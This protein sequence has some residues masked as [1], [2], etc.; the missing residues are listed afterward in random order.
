MKD[1][2]WI[3]L[4]L[5]VAAIWGF[6]FTATK[7]ALRSFGTFALLFIRFFIASCLL[8]GYIAATRKKFELHNA[9]GGIVLGV[10]A[11]F[12]YATQTFGLNFTSAANSAFITYLLVIFVPILSI[13]ILKKKPHRKMW[14]A[15]AIAMA[16]L[17]LLNGSEGRFNIGD[18]I[19]M[20]C[21]VA[22][23]LH[24]I[25]N[26]KFVRNFQ[27]H[28]LLF[29]QFATVMVLSAIFMLALGEVPADYPDAA[30][31]SV[32]FLAVFGSVFAHWVQLEVQK[33]VEPS[34]V[35]LVFITEPIFAAAFGMVLLGESLALLQG[36]G[37]VLMLAA[38]ALEEYEKIQI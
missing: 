20:L 27:V 30:V 1:A 3:A 10:I 11:F 32:L 17:Y 6:T 12:A 18:A 15:A 2:K 31:A 29:W 37:A 8:S 16:G 28:S 5:L 23:A 9:K 14:V 19:T 38:I 25:Y 26:D 21:A 13:F 24:V 4:L 33:F 22:F 36:I 34:R 7:D 35:G